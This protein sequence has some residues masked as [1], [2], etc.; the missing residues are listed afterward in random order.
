MGVS[1]SLDPDQALVG[2]GL[3]PNCLQMLSADPSIYQNVL[4]IANL[5]ESSIMH[6]V[7]A[8]TA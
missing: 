4:T 7:H 8:V 2:L 6:C 1:D 3:S 5:S